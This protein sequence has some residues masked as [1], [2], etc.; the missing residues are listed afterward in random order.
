VA[1]VKAFAIGGIEMWFGSGDHEPA[2]FHARRRGEWH[3]KVR[4]L[5]SPERMI[6]WLRPLDATIKGRDRRAIIAGVEE[7]RAALL[8]EWEVCQGTG[9]NE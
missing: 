4:I 3:A 8:A 1:Q 9:Q 5:E 2:H 7:N 6:Y